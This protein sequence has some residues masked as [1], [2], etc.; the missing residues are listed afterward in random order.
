MIKTIIIMSSILLLSACSDDKF[1]R[2]A[3]GGLYKVVEKC[4]VVPNPNYG[5]TRTS[6]LLLG[7][8]L[9]AVVGKKV[10]NNKNIGTL[11]GAALGAIIASEP[12]N[13]YTNCRNV[14]RKVKSK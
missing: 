1:V 13:L 4:D 7:A 3:D 6:N 12:K 9:G 14:Y 10:S 8:G 5:H 2:S 11:T